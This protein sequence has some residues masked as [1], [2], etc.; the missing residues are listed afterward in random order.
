M[1]LN[2]FVK[3]TRA[4]RRLSKL[5]SAGMLLPKLANSFFKFSVG[6]ITDH[7]REGKPKTIHRLQ[8]QE[9]EQQT[10]AAIIGHISFDIYQLPFQNR[11]LEHLNLFPRPND[12]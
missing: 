10:G 7:W 4:W 11:W 2:Q 5:C 3:T 1:L 8:N 12:K 6:S 9:Q